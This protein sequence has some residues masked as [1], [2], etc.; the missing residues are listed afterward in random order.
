[1]PDNTKERI[2]RGD[3]TQG[4]ILK[5]VLMF[6][7]PILL[8]N[9]FSV[10][11]NLVDSITVG[12]YVGSDALA[13]VGSCF[14][15]IMVM[16]AIYAGFGIG[17]G[18][19]V[20]QL[21]GAK[22]KDISKAVNTA[23]IVAFF[24]GIVM[25]IVGQIVAKPLLN[26][27]RTPANINNDALLYL[28]IIFLGCTGELFYYMG[29][30]LLRSMGD[31][32]WP[33]YFGIITAILNIIGDIILVVI[34]KIG[35]AGVAIATIGSQAVSAILVLLRVYK[36]K[37]FDFKVTRETFRPDF[38]ILKN[39]LRIGIPSAINSL[40]NSI[41]LL[42]IQS[43]A[44]SFGSDFVAC[45]TIVQKV[46]SF[47]LLPLMALG[48]GLMT[49]S[50]QNL[51][52]DREDRVR[53]GLMK[54]GSFMLIFILISGAAIFIF[55]APLS[56]AFTTNEAVI[57]LCVRALRIVSVFYCAVAVQRSVHAM[58]QGSG[59]MLPI[60]AVSLFAIIVRILL[61]YL[62]AVRGNDAFGLMWAQ[63][64]S[65]TLVAVLSLLYAMFGNWKKYVVVKKEA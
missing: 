64:I 4:P 21:Y 23:Y 35:V 49:F 11:Y 6:S 20:A 41:G 24:V 22:S 31:S 38:G 65:N 58:L 45:N 36:S 46:D 1:M 26:L 30:G 55:A 47:A 44:N 15:I 56:R 28:R 7:I 14:A 13:A 51:G 29:S 54:I 48:Q 19:L 43:Y 12:Q 59:A 34:I 17:S 60:M 16:V 33:M 8:S 2:R 42:I 27:L 50:G 39:I 3:L 32:K 9:I 63:N 61:S 37:S 53:S 62:L 10:L 57:S 18:V 25:G 40:T 52:A 5:K